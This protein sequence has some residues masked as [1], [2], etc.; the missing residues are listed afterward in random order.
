M[1]LAFIW[2]LLGRTGASALSGEKSFSCPF[3]PR[4]KLNLA[5]IMEHP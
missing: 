3:A 1:L 4:Y 5:V 2:M